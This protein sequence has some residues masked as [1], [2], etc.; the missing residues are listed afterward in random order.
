M[1]EEP[2]D[3]V[4]DP[5]ARKA[6]QK[7]RGEATAAAD[8]GNLSELGGSTGRADG[9]AKSRGQRKKR[10]VFKRIWRQVKREA[11]TREG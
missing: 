2:E 8:K 9:S 1:V 11:C 5:E 4:S 7:N 6:E 3:A 10:S